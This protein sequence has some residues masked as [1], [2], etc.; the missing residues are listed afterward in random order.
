MLGVDL[1]SAGEPIVEQYKACGVN[2]EGTLLTLTTK[3]EMVTYTRNLLQRKRAGNPPYL[4]LPRSG[5]FVPELLAQMKEQERIVGAGERP[6]YDHPSGRHD[7]LLWALNIACYL[8]RRWL[9][10]THWVIRLPPRDMFMPRR[11]EG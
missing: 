9:S 4:V 8:A 1:G 7:D 11:W 2:A 5:E 10:N 6:Q 3:D